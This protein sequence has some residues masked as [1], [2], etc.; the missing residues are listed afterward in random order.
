MNPGVSLPQG[1]VAAGNL[2][3]HFLHEL[4]LSHGSFK[5]RAQVARD[6]VVV[7]VARAGDSEEEKERRDAGK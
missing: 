5:L 4:F 6:V 2:T 1:Y 7:F 3:R